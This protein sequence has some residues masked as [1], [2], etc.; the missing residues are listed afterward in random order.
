MLGP[1]RVLDLTDERC[2]FAGNLLAQLGAD[3]VLAEPP[4]GWPRGYSH[5]AYNRGKR[6]V[7]V[8]SAADVAALAATAD[9]VLHN[10]GT[11]FEI[12]LAAMRESNDQLITVHITPWGETGPKADWQADDLVLFA[13]SG[14]LAVTGDSDRPPVRISIPQAWLH[15]CAQAAVAALVALEHRARMGRGQHIDL[16]TQQAVCETAL[17]AILY[18]PAGLA[19]VQREAGGVR[20]GD[21][22]LRTIY[23]CKDGYII[24]TV[25]FG[26][27]IGPMVRRF[28][29]WMHAEGF[30]D[31]DTLNKDWVNF[32]LQLQTGEESIDVIEGL[33][34]D[35]ARF[36]LTKTKA[37]MIERGLQDSLLICPVNTLQDVLDSPQLA[38]RNFWD[39]VDGARMPGRLVLAGATPLHIL[40]P[41]PDAGQHTAEVIAAGDARLASAPQPLSADAR[42][43]KPLA[44]LKVA[45]LSWV[46]AAP[47][48]TKIL[49]HWGAT[50][51]RVETQNRPCLL[52]GALGHRDD[53]PDQENAIAWHS[54]N[55][56][57][58]TISLN[59]SKPEA[60]DVVRDLAA[61]ADVVVESF[62][63][64]TMAAWGLGYDDLRDVNPELVMVSSCVMGQTG[65]FRQFAGFGNMAAS[66]AGFFDITGWADRGPAGPYLAYTDYCSPRFTV[67]A[68]LAALDHRRRTGEGQ[69]LDF[70]QM[71]AAVHLLA[72][73]IAELQDTGDMRSRRGNDD[74]QMVPHGAYPTAGDDE[75]IAISVEDDEQ[76]RSLATEMRQEDLAVLD[77]AASTRW[78]SSKTCSATTPNASPSWPSPRP[79]SER[80]PPTTDPGSG[81]ETCPSPATRAFSTNPQ[82]TRFLT[83]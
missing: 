10:D 30:C 35:I 60:R 28:L 41:A 34:D 62:T 42:T 71:E 82:D 58:M 6:S 18:A 74:D 59:L 3:V 2:W 80:V 76:W 55:A 16:S 52:R 26:P 75:W 57:K 13:S 40:G 70:S 20:F 11:L 19:E 1:Y 47:L 29:T 23:P 31:D 83:S 56:N 39:D 77:T 81:P 72:P 24:V 49:A 48:A 69:H 22:M 8:A 63:P 15:G 37:E 78:K 50:V 79:S 68:L 73:A 54:T 66:I 7:T 44:G 9:I 5:D 61:W 33:M 65:P 32:A 51:V 67:C 43:D 25:A 36:C 64:G 17:S 12:D 46:A 45:D 4:G 27:M 14:Q 21:L 38:D 53:V